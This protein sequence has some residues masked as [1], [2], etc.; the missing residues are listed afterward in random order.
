[1]W[2]HL[3]PRFSPQLAQPATW[4]NLH[5][6]TKFCPAVPLENSILEYLIDVLDHTDINLR[7]IAVE[8]FAKLLIRDRVSHP[9]VLFLL[10]NFFVTN[11]SDVES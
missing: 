11:L 1:M 10:Q 5:W 2:Y 3:K 8:G 7:R 9:V 6:P 4:V